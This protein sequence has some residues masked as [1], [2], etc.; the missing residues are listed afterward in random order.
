MTTKPA[1]SLEDLA[2]EVI[3]TQQGLSSLDALNVLFSPPSSQGDGDPQQPVVEPTPAPTAVAPTANVPPTAAEP[4]KGEPDVLKL[5]PDKFR[6]KDVQSSVEKMTKS[7][8]ELEAQLKREQDEKANM[9]RILDSLAAPRP[10]HSPQIQV[11][12]DDDVDDAAF[13]ERPKESVAKMAERIAAQKVLQYHADME[14]ARFIEGFRV[15]HPEFDQLRPEIMEVLAARP[16]LDRDQRNL[17]IVFE[18]ARQ[19]KARKL[20]DLRASL[21]IQPLQPAPPYAPGPA[22]PAQG[23]VDR[24]QLKAELLEAIK[25]ELSKRRA[26]S[27]IQGGSTPVNPSD[28]MNQPPNQKPLTPE[29]MILK[30]M[31]ESGP[32]KLGIDLD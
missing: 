1:K 29:D 32:K 24:E 2:K 6:D 26:A 20:A 7:Y 18:M 21:G 25:A 8:T 16:D 17:P 12:Q 9:Q 4:P 28:R 23:P 19:V 27:G 30:E 10:V 14:K 15:T 13:F 3:D 5:V 11:P 31:M 22:N